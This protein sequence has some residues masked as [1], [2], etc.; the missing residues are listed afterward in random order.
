MSN[1]GPA[2][3]HYF[4]GTGDPKN[5]PVAR[6]DLL[7]KVYRRYFTP[8]GKY[9]PWLVGADLTEDV[10]ERLVQLLPPVFTMQ[11]LFCVLPVWIPPKFHGRRRFSIRLAWD[12][13]ATRSSARSSK[14]ATTSYRSPHWRT[15]WKAWKKMSRRKRTSLCVSMDEEGAE[16]LLVT[17]S[18]DFFAE[19]HVGLIGYAKVFHQAH[20]LDLEL[21]ASEAANFGLFIGGYENMRKVALRVRE[22]ALDWASNASCL[23]N[24]V[25][26]CNTA[27]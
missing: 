19:P 26:A 6:Q 17:P 5:M 10:F 11:T 7:R 14:S 24:V 9:V 23:V 15:L 16:V 18:A 8:A 1:V 2:K 25:T 13:T 20:Q 12:S 4:L 21:K 3:C 27:S 22:A